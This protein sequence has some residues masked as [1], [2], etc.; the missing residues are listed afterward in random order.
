[1][2]FRT[3]IRFAVIIACSTF[4][5]PTAW[6]NQPDRLSFLPHWCPQA[7]FAGFYVAVEKGFYRNHGIDLD[8]I[9]GSP[10]RSPVDFLLHQK[11]DVVTLWLS[12]AIQLAASGA[13]LVNLAQLI[14]R[15]ALI[16]V[17]QKY[18]VIR[19][20]ADMNGKKIAMWPADFQIQPKAFFHRLGLNV[21]PVTAGNTLNLFLRGAVDLALVMWYNE[22]HTLLTYG[23]EPEE[24]QTFFF[25][26]YDLNFPEDG[27][28]V[29]GSTWA[30]K[31]G[32]LCRFVHA[33]MEG[34]DYAFR[35]PEEALDIV[36]RAMEE[37]FV[38]ANRTHQRWM[39]NRIQE[40]YVP[41]TASIRPGVLREADFRHV[42]EVLQDEKL[43]AAPP[44]FE[45]FSKGCIH[46]DSP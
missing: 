14:Q 36:I 8:F 16:M 40:L 11:A 45:Y 37:N 6:G 1:M 22:Y 29:L 27:I 25:Q 20:I 12:T 44:N 43:I 46:D 5:V 33:S 41:N 31:P 23:I 32:L 3:V 2:L 19:S 30:Q 35:H 15:S 38:P 24:L 39:L 28:Y 42:C 17:A 18:G 7:Q 10:N 26:D 9:Q 21:T 13:D 34:W 4:L